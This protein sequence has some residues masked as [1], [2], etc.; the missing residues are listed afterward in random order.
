MTHGLGDLIDDIWMYKLVL[1]KFLK[2][3]DGC[4]IALI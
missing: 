2:L 1:N 4:V 3:G